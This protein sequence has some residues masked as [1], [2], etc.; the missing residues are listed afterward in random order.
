MPIFDPAIF[1]PAIF[2]TVPP[3]AKIGIFD[4]AIFDPAIFDTGVPLGPQ[5]HVIKFFYLKL[6]RTREMDLER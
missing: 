4:P 5:Y 1:D 6:D 3:A 2:D